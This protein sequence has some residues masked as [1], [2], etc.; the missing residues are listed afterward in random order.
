MAY[1]YVEFGKK[2]SPKTTAKEAVVDRQMHQNGWLLSCVPN[3]RWPLSAPTLP[4]PTH[5]PTVPWHLCVAVS[6]PDHDVLNCR[7]DTTGLNWGPR[8]V[9]D[10][11][12]LPSLVTL[13]SGCPPRR[14][15]PTTVAAAASIDQSAR[16]QRNSTH[17]ADFRV[18]VAKFAQSSVLPVHI[19]KSVEW[20]QVVATVTRRK[21]NRIDDIGHN[22]HHQSCAPQSLGLR[23]TPSSP[24]PTRAQSSKPVRPFYVE[25]GSFNCTTL[26]RGWSTY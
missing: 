4:L 12:A 9:L 15:S 14:S 18:E 25:L 26:C 11:P 24:H 17:L 3:G 10:A 21:R 19:C 16:L 8:A 2:K 22:Q 1:K 20:A 13:E 6:T 7:Q 5:S 23:Q